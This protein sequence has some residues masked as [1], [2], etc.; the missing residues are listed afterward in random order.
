MDSEN[1][2]DYLADYNSRYQKNGTLDPMYAEEE[3]VE[4][5]KG[6]NQITASNTTGST[7][8]TTYTTSDAAK[9]YMNEIQQI[10]AST[11]STT[12][13]PQ[14]APAG[15][16]AQQR[17]EITIDTFIPPPPNKNTT[18]TTTS[19]L[20]SGGSSYESSPRIIQ[21]VKLPSSPYDE[22]VAFEQ[23]GDEDDEELDST[24]VKVRRTHSQ[25]ELDHFWQEENQR[26]LMT[27]ATFSEVHLPSSLKAAL[28]DNTNPKTSSS[29]KIERP[30]SSSTGPPTRGVNLRTGGDKATTTIGRNFNPNSFNSGL[31]TTSKLER[32]LQRLAQSVNFS[33][34]TR[35]R[36]ADSRSKLR[37]SYS[38]GGGNRMTG[39]AAVATNKNTHKSSIEQLN[40]MKDLVEDLVRSTVKK[41]D[42]YHMIQV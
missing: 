29:V 9:E 17:G 37:N 5:R 34:R 40:V 18:T 28:K 38:G 24:Y 3:E 41:A 23:D 25:Q 15:K 19:K 35:S 8:R 30:R 7:T 10:S 20:T 1:R 31:G 6:S 14:S 32:D 39:A 16:R 27:S 12:S 33:S 4:E 21:T 22:E 36:S 11:S 2:F 26:L 42:L 13:R